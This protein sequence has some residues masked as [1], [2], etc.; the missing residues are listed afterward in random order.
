MKIA[1]V[2]IACLAAQAAP[3]ERVDDT[4]F[5]KF[6][7]VHVRAVQAI[8]KSWKFGVIVERRNLNQGRHQWS[9]FKAGEGRSAGVNVSPHTPSL[10]PTT[11]NGSHER[12]HSLS[13]W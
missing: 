11:L 7:A 5:D 4:D 12:Q 3:E 2:L 10:F 6:V 13:S 8:E 9:A 1:A